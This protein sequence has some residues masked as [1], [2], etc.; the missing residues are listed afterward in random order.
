M[1]KDSKNIRK[2]EW[3][4]HW[5]FRNAVFP[6]EDK[7]TDKWR[8][9]SWLTSLIATPSRP[10]LSSGNKQVRQEWQSVFRI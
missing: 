9:V 10:D 6:S 4:T 8:Q 5:K 2:Y 3:N 7:R 1:K